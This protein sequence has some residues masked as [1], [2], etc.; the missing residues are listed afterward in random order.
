MRDMLDMHIPYLPLNRSQVNFIELGAISMV[1]VALAVRKLTICLLFLT[2]IYIPNLWAN[3]PRYFAMNKGFSKDY[4]TPCNNATFSEFAF[5]SKYHHYRDQIHI[6]FNLNSNSDKYQTKARSG[7]EINSD[8]FGIVLGTAAVTAISMVVS[9]SIYYEATGEILW[10]VPM[11]VG[12]ITNVLFSTFLLN[13]RQTHSAAKCFLI[14]SCTWL[15]FNIP[16]FIIKDD[17]LFITVPTSIILAPI[18][19]I[20]FGKK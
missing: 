3:S 18:S 17:A 2:G 14:S 20:L 6:R 8:Y 19:A 15:I 9:L 10:Q 5:L 7:N 16:T 12:S 1:L 4:I 11:T 13:L